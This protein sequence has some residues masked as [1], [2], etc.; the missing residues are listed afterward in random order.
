MFRLLLSLVLTLMLFSAIQAQESEVAVGEIKIPALHWGSQTADVILTN[1]SEYMKVIVVAIDIT[2]KGGELLPNRFVRTNFII[3]P[4][5]TGTIKP[6][7]YIPGSYGKADLD[8]RVYDV[9]DTLDELL[10]HQLFYENKSE[11][12]YHYPDELSDYFKTKIHLPPRVEVHP[13]FNNEFV[14]LFFILLKEGKSLKEIAEMT[15]AELSFIEEQALKLTEIRFLKFNSVSYELNFAVILAD[16]AEAT[17]ALIESTSDK[18]ASL[19]VKNYQD[20]FWGVI[21]S[22]VETKTIPRD[23]NDFVSGATL[24]YRPYPIISGLLLWFDLG[25][26]FITRMAPLLIYDGTDIC[27]A[28]NFQYM[29]A[30][31]GDEYFHGKQF[32]F[33]NYKNDHKY[34]LLFSETAPQLSCEKDFLTKNLKVRKANWGF[35][36]RIYPEFFIVDTAVTRP[37]LN[38]LGEGAGA[39][40]EDSYNQLRTIALKHGHKT[41]QYGHRYWFWNIVSERTLAKINDTGVINKKGNGYYKYESLISH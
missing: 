9:I 10:D 11:I 7:I 24:L 3:E 29:Y 26:K 14:R 15:H 6:E 20:G 32:F 39:I 34:Y 40:L 25:Q 36:N 17:K 41:V 12:E 38:Q 31:K 35:T 23:S 8:I 13:N 37:I 28:S 16:E 22:L 27:R 19:I 21:D 2:F 4:N 1:S 5:W 18:L 30:V 33:L